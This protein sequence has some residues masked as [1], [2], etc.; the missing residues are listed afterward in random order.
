[1][2]IQGQCNSFLLNKLKGAEDFSA[3]S[4]YQYYIALYTADAD[5]TQ[6]TLIYTTSHEVVGAGYT[7]GGQLLTPIPPM[8]SNGVAYVSFQN[9]LWTGAAFITRGALIYNFTTQ[10]AVCV[11]DFGA[12]KTASGTFNVLFP[13]ATYTTAI[14]R[15]T[16]T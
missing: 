12:D 14:I 11:L 5:I 9:P 13:P 3:P 7:A 4:P 6:D 15:D 8:L 2:V 1:M 10:A 16:T